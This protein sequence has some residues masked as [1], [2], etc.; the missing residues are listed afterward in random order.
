[1]RPRA[2]ALAL[3]LLVASAAIAIQYRRTALPHVRYDRF[4]LP[5]FD[6]YVYVAMADH[7]AV[8]TVAPWGYRVLTPWLAR[9]LPGNVARGFRVVT[10]G[11]LV[12]SALLLW[13]L[14]VRL[15][16]G[17]WA[18][19]AGVLAF[20]LSGPVAESLRLRMLAEPLTLALEVALLLLAF[21]NAG[22]APLALVA[23]LGALAKESFLLL[24]PLVFL[25]RR[26]HVGPAA[27]A[28]LTVLVAGPAL[29]ATLL[30]R[31]WWTPHLAL[32]LPGS[33]AAASAVHRLT[34][35]WR[36]WAPS[37]LLGGIGLLALAGSLRAAAR[38]LRVP[39]LYLAL[40][41][42]LPPL[43]NPVAFF[44]QDIP[45]L[46]L[47]VLPL[48]VPLALIAV[49]RVVPLWRAPAA[50]AAAP[51]RAP[52]WPALACAA[53]ALLAAL[54]PLLLDRYRRLDLRGARD[55]P[56]VL[57]TVRETLRTAARLERGQAV[58]LGAESHRFVWGGSDPGQLRAMRWFLREGWGPLAHYETGDIV[59][60]AAR[61]SLIVPCRRRRDLDA[62]LTMDAPA[63]ARMAFTLN[64]HLLGEGELGPQA[65]RLVLRLPRTALFEGDNLLVLEQRA[66]GAGARLHRLVLQAVP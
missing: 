35:T 13:V 26:R 52:R 36:E 38:P 53:A 8:F 51:A 2:G 4:D 21:G 49:D 65:L 37:T 6:P 43:L 41:T 62:E 28:R 48:V 40:A 55:G 32:V 31:L 66:G 18:A 1:M 3:A 47:Y 20:T 39:A 17:D 9:A 61:A 10:V 34:A 14:L 50:A 30:L 56:L 57:A 25:V 19:V 11:A 60:R 58:S 15:G 59:M 42:L 44:A 29:L 5:A 63:P 64:G 27:A 46:L 33:G 24:L 54:S 45:R 7:P 22:A 12:A 16:C 23:V